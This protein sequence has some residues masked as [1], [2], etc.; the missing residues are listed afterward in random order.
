MLR[1]RSLNLAIAAVLLLGIGLAAWWMT[2]WEHQ[3]VSDE[4]VAET[5]PPL[6]LYTS[7]PIYWDEAADIGEM[8]SADSGKHWVREVLESRYELRPVDVLSYDSLAGLEFLLIAQPRILAPQE[9]VA[10]DDWVRTGGRLMLFADPLLTE[11]SRFPI[12]DPR[13]PQD[14]VLISPILAR[15]GLDLQYDPGQA[16]APRSVSFVG[17]KVPVHLFG[18]FAM[19]GTAQDA[20]AD[21]NVT[22]AK[23]L[24][25]CD[26]GE[27]RVLAV[28][29]AA[30]LNASRTRLDAM[31]EM[32]DPEIDPES[33]L[34]KLVE[35]VFHGSV[36]F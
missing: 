22:G 17:T 6:G 16:P 24:V 14:V 19:Q 12:G 18:T 26:I 28:A 21:C 15:W 20:P 1:P 13:R 3:P 2:R 8:L 10:L 30:L 9:N 25:W 29:D 36:R 35:T 7:L 23:V 32:A 33:V 31:V 11:E 4:T 27:G 5:R 34:M